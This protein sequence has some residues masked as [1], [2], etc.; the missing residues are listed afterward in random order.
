LA[1]GISPPTTALSPLTST[2][3]GFASEVDTSAVVRIEAVINALNP[4]YL[5]DDLSIG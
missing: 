4:R 5:M 3:T 2:Q 1:E